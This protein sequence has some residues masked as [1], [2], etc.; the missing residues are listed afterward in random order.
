MRNLLLLC[1]KDVHFGFDGNMYQQNDGVAM[2]TCSISHW[3][4][5]VD[6]TFVFIEKDFVEHVLACLNLFHKNIKFTY[7]WKIATSYHF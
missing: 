3:K 2:V 5:Y 1:I 7:E 4:S 6:D